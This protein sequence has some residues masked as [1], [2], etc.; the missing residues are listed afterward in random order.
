MKKIELL[1]DISVIHLPRNKY[2][3]CLGAGDEGTVYKYDDR[4]AIKVFSY[5][6]IGQELLKYAK[7][8]L[9]SHLQDESFAFPIGYVYNQEDM[10]IGYYMN[11]IKPHPLYE[12]FKALYLKGCD[13]QTL[14][15]NQSRC[16]IAK[17]SSKRNYTGRY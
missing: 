4:Y 14:P 16:D 5:F 2:L 7:I 8:K 13:K 15:F 9:L 1:D 11:L 3:E 12:S 17:S 6:E 10:L